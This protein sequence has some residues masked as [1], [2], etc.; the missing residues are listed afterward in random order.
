MTHNAS[1]ILGFIVGL[2]LVAVIVLLYKKATGT[3]AAEY[4]ERQQML[5]GIGYKYAYFTLLGIGVVAMLIMELGIKLPINGLLLYFAGILISLLVYVGYCVRKDAY[6]G[7]NQ[8]YNRYIALCVAVAVFNLIPL[9]GGIMS[10]S[11][12]VNGMISD[13]YGLNILCILA[14]T[15]VGIMLAVKKAGEK[16]EE[17]DFDEES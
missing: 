5:R 10:K 3:S 7:L 8:N 4:D 2:L 13:T 9:V 6:L 1:Y 12:I 17:V 16:T 14:F 15:A 11:L